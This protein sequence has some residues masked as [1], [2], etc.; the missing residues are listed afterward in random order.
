MLVIHV[1]DVC[2]KKGKRYYW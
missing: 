2:R 1:K